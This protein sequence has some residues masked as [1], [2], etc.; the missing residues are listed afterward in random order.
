MSTHHELP[1]TPETMVW[2]YFDAAQKPVLEVASGDTVTLHALPAF[3]PARLPS[4]PAFEVPPILAEA[5]ARL[6]PGPATH[7]LSGPIAV[8][9]AVPGDVLEIEILD[10]RPWM[11]WGYVAIMPLRGTIP[12]DFPEPAM[13]HARI[14]AQ[15]GI[16][17]MLPGL[18]IPLDP[19]F[20]VLATAPAP[21]WGRLSTIVPRAFGGNMD[22]K[23]FR[24]G[25]KVYLPVFVPG[26][27]FSAGDGHG[28]Q[29]DGE[30]CITALETGMRGTFRLTVRKDLR[31]AW[32]FAETQE[33]LISIGLDEDLDDA[34]KQATREMIL[35]VTRLTRLTREQ[36]YM[37][38]S[39]AGDLRVTQTV[40]GNKGVHM[41]LRKSLLDGSLRA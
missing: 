32:P 38:C 24:V 22:N 19:F 10:I 9:G 34:A 20:G 25:A 21:S 37:L 33:H 39:L 15:A 13:I 35:H 28:V 6:P 17:H 7:F 1:L 2:G 29:G 3:S 30:V 40:D 41:M 23:E 12:E 4:D 36:A 18:D 27:S 14:E 31:L 5:M 11:D 26:A 8:G 16:V